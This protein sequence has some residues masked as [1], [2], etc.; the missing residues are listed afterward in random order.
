MNK[1]KVLLVEDTLTFAEIIRR[2][3]EREN[4]EVTHAING[5]EALQMAETNMPDIVL[6]DV[7]MPLCNGFEFCKAFRLLPRSVGVPFIFLTNQ[8]ESA[9]VRTGMRL[10]ADDYIKKSSSGNEIIEAINVRLQ[11]KKAIEEEAI[12]LV[13]NLTSEIEKRD[14]ILGGIAKNES[15]VIRAPLAAIM[16][17]VSMIDID[18]MSEKNKKLVSMLTPLTTQLDTVI[19]ENVY[20]INNL[21]KEADDKF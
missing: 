6:C 12:K 1:P 5:N 20:A 10:G 3:L 4:F 17:I 14:I 2:F 18:E 19:R 13:F 15:H 7:Q 21:N 11:K 8:T 16:Q 9:D